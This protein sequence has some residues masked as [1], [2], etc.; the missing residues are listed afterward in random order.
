MEFQF[1][2][3]RSHGL[4][5]FKNKLSHFASDRHSKVA[6]ELRFQRAGTWGN[7]ASEPGSPPPAPTPSILSQ[8]VPR[9][10]LSTMIKIL[11]S[12]LGVS[13]VATLPNRPG[14]PLGV[15]QLQILAPKGTHPP[16]SL[17]SQHIATRRWAE[18]RGFFHLIHEVKR[19]PFP[20]VCHSKP[21][22]VG[23]SI[24]QRLPT[25]RTN[26]TRA[27]SFSTVTTTSH[28]THK[29]FARCRL[30]CNQLKL[31]AAT[32]CERDGRLVCQKE[33]QRNH[34]HTCVRSSHNPEAVGCGSLICP[35]RHHGRRS[36]PS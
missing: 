28:S 4:D 18:T 20:S 21:Y 19:Q 17:G 7:K 6:L 22:L 8:F 1:Y 33:I 16:I 14:G 27:G 34:S 9:K 11:V 25:S 2:L 5:I 29:S 13:S 23:D 36:P 15:T 35:I 3:S 26:P 24:F 12:T 31:D 10:F 30:N 32:P